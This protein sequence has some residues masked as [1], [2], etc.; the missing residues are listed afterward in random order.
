MGQKEGS[1]KEKSA[2]ACNNCHIAKKRCE[3]WEIIFDNGEI[4]KFKQYRKWSNSR[5]ECIIPP[6]CVQCNKK[7]LAIGVCTKEVC[8]R[9]QNLKETLRLSQKSVDE[10][11]Q[12]IS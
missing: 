12:K 1:Q 6:H 9:F 7:L 11:S 10:K 3:G 8:K 2:P 5:I 4:K